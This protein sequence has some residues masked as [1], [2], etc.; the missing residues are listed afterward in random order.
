MG[1]QKHTSEAITRIDFVQ[2]DQ[3]PQIRYVGNPPCH[4]VREPLE[5]RLSAM[6]RQIAQWTALRET[7]AWLRYN[8]AHRISRP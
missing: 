1:Y 6:G 8:A 4:Q 2:I 3:F 5:M 7:I